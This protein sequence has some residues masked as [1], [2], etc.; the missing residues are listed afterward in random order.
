MTEGIK[1][2]RPACTRTQETP[3]PIIKICM[4]IHLLSFS[5]FSPF[6]LLYF[7]KNGKER[8]DRVTFWAG[9]GDLSLLWWSLVMERIVYTHTISRATKIESDGLNQEEMCDCSVTCHPSCSVRLE[10]PQLAL[11]QTSS[12]K[13]PSSFSDFF[14]FENLAARIQK[15]KTPFLHERSVLFHI[16]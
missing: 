16:W 6:F 2:Y 8:R 1:E 14:R 10:N 5:S 4:Y 15:I 12:D 3:R 9:D 11:I 7:K 13:W